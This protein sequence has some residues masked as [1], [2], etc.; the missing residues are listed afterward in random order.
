MLFAVP[1]L[2]LLA[3]A[4]LLQSAVVSAQYNQSTSFSNLFYAA[5]SYCIA[6]LKLNSWTCNACYFNPGFQMT[7]FLQGVNA[8]YGFVGVNVVESQIVVAFKGTNPKNLPN[9]ILDLSTT[10]VPYTLIGSAPA[11]ALVHQGF[12][13][14]YQSMRAPM[15]AAVAALVAKYPGF[16]LTFTG[17]SMGGVSAV[18]AA[19]DVTEV[20]ANNQQTMPAV[21][22][23]YGQPRMGNPAFAAWASA[24]LAARTQGTWRSVHWRDPVPHLPP[25]IAFNFEQVGTEVWY[26]SGMTTYQVCAAYSEDPSCSDSISAWDITDHI[27]YFGIRVGDDCDRKLHFDASQ[28]QQE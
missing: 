1:G 15:L 4:T 14:G 28:F 18:F 16:S 10:L 25:T 22:Y 8:T 2:L 7:Q 12:Y 6:Y 27:T 3:A 17:H 5:S 11:Q 13:L 24:L 9:W 26:Q 20:L 21:V 19:L 23:T